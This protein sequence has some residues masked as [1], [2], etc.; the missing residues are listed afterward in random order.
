MVPILLLSRLSIYLVSIPLGIGDSVLRKTD[1][2]QYRWSTIKN[3]QHLAHRGS[4]VKRGILFPSFP[5]T[6]RGNPSGPRC[7]LKPTDLTYDGSRGNALAGMCHIGKASCSEVYQMGQASRVAGE[8]SHTPSCS[9][10][11][12]EQGVRSLPSL[13]LL[14]QAW[15]PLRTL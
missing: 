5:G 15:I 1:T 10:S 11:V 14:G 3:V 13:D 8:S 2:S 4:P 6:S 12:Q 7:F 9:A